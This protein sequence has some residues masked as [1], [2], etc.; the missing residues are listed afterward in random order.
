MK[1]STTFYID[2]TLVRYVDEMAARYGVSRSMALCR[3]LLICR[4]TPKL[5][6]FA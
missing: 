3:M 4:A 1:T 5:N 2:E 6:L